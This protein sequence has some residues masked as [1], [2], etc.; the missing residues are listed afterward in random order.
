MQNE[1]LDSFLGC[2]RTEDHPQT[3]TTERNRANFCGGEVGCAGR[4][5]LCSAEVL[6][7]LHRLELLLRRFLLVMTPAGLKA[8]AIAPRNRRQR[9]PQITGES[10]GLA[11]GAASSTSRTLRARASRVN[12][13]WR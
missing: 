5:P 13:F 12:G 6:A 8:K 1:N 2:R 10:A 4:L 11:P 9:S 7:A 3:R